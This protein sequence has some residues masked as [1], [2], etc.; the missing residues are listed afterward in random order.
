[1][2]KEMTIIL[3]MANSMSYYY[4]D[5]FNIPLCHMPTTHYLFP[6]NV[7]ITYGVLVVLKNSCTDTDSDG[8]NQVNGKYYINTCSKQQQVV[9]IIHDLK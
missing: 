5:V 9:Y 6:G 2:F 8:R 3:T 1:M 4:S 7:I